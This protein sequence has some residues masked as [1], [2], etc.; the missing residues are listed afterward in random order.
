MRQRGGS[1]FV[2][3]ASSDLCMAGWLWFCM[4]EAAVVVLYGR[5]VH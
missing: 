1:D 4:G 3:E 2:W 5:V